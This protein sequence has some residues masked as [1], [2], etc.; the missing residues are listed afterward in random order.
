MQRYRTIQ[1]SFA[2]GTSAKVLSRSLV[3]R[4]AEV[5][6]RSTYDK[7]IQ[8]AGLLFQDYGY[9]AV[10]IRDIVSAVHVPKGTFYN[11][12]ASKETLA[13]SIV[14]QQFR[15]LYSPLPQSDD[16]DIRRKLRLYFHAVSSLPQQKGLC[17]L[18]LLGT[19]AAESLVL[20]PLL[21]TQVVSGIGNWSDDLAKLLS[22][23]KDHGELNA[24]SAPSLLANVLVSGMLGAAIQ[25]KCHVSV[26]PLQAFAEFALDCVL[27]SKMGDHRRVSS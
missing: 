17:P 2:K 20:P 26:V 13:V 21:R 8:S 9:V 18:R 16:G 15:N 10:S 25:A 27:L 24:V 22:S 19:L 12:F 23:A 4:G 14:E 7:L 11:Y 5:R 6:G 3:R 1:L